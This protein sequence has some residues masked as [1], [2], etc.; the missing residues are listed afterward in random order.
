MLLQT[1]KPQ[2]IVPPLPKQKNLFVA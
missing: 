2:S 1:A